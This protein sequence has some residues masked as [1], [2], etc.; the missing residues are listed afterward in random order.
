MTQKNSV[1]DKKLKADIAENAVITRLLKL[2]F[3]VLKP[4]GDRLPYDLVIEHRNKFIKIQVKSAWFRNDVY[5]VDS[6]RTLTNRRLMARKRYSKGDFDFAILYLDD[7]DIFY[8]L[9]FQAFDS[10]KSGITIVERKTRQRK[11]KSHTYREAWHLLKNK[12]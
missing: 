8:V 2:G 3:N 10:F 12:P 7:L 6:R 11:P 5:T 4:I 1:K 9:P